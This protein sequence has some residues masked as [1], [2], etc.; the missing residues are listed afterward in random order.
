[1]S[2]PEFTSVQLP[3][4]DEELDALDAYRRDRKSPPSWARAV[5]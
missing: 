1:M 4:R 3:L 5:E 2:S